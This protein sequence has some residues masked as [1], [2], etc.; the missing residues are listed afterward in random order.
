MVRACSTSC[1]QVT[2]ELNVVYNSV[3]DKDTPSSTLLFSNCLSNGKSPQLAVKTIKVG[4]RKGNSAYSCIYCGFTTPPTV[5]ELS[6]EICRHTAHEA[7]MLLCDHCNRGYHTFCLDP[8]LFEIPRTAW[9]CSNC[10]VMYY[11]PA[12]LS[13]CNTCGMKKPIQ[14]LLIPPVRFHTHPS[15]LC[16]REL[17]LENGVC[18][19]PTSLTKEQ[20]AACYHAAL[21]NYNQNIRTIRQKDLVLELEEVG[22]DTFKLRQ[23]GRYDAVIHKLNSANFSFLHSHAPWRAFVESLL[24]D[25]CKQVHIGCML[26]VPNSERQEWH[27]DGPHLSASHHQKPKWVNVFI[28]L[29]DM[30]LEHGPTEF[31]PGSHLNWEIGT[32]PVVF[33]PNAGDVIIFDY[34]IK[35]RGLSNRSDQPR[36]VIYITYSADA[37]SDPWNFSTKRYYAMPEPTSHDRPQRRS[38]QLI[39]L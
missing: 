31:V 2:L 9:F 19:F 11:S 22:F 20:V 16:L 17:F 38:R 1:T 24:G 30:K 33:T 34:R 8:P 12:A 36:P 6:C 39:P 29:I 23:R 4:E 35:H 32:I 10:T 27:S 25:K 37:A 13:S 18:V 14:R 28:P 26:S 3:Q 15:E 21:E 7:E 5:D